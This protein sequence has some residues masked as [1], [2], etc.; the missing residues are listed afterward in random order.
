MTAVDARDA[1]LLTSLRTGRGKGKPT[2]ALGGTSPLR[3]VE[4]LFAAL[5]ERTADR[6][7]SEL[8]GGKAGQGSLETA[9]GRARCGND[10]DVVGVHASSLSV[11]ETSSLGSVAARTS[12]TELVVGIAVQRC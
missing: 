1:Y 3:L 6:D 7:A 4:T 8:G 5:V 12:S 9:L 11:S 10:D 2:G